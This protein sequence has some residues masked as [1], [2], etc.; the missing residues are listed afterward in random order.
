[1][2]KISLP[3]LTSWLAGFHLVA[4][5]LDLSPTGTSFCACQSFAFFTGKDILTWGEVYYQPLPLEV[6]PVSV[7]VG[8]KLLVGHTCW[9]ESNEDLFFVIPNLRGEI[10]A[11]RFSPQINMEEK[12]G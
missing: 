9:R 6:K 12:H 7:N 8:K 3:A 4:C 2:R 11:G 5:R 10:P 1:M